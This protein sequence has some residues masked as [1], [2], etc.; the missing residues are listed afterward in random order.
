MSQH[1]PEFMRS[2]KTAKGTEGIV[3][4]RA[5][6]DIVIKSRKLVLH[7]LS[8]I[9]KLSTEEFVIFANIL[10]PLIRNSLQ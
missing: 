4:V 7:A 3:I 6:V 5:V 8:L 10:S 2:I 9:A 1:D